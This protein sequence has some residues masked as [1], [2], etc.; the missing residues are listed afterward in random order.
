MLGFTKSKCIHALLASA[1]TG[2]DSV[3]RLW[4]LAKQKCIT[5]FP[6]GKHIET[7]TQRNPHT[8][9]PPYSESPKLTDTRCLFDNPIYKRPD[10][11][12]GLL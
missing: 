1:Q 7:P 12:A 11:R 10:K 8:A 3:V 9:K 4:T 5:M 6:T 2:D